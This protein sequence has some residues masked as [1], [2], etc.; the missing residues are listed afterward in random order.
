MSYV[1]IYYDTYRRINKSWGMPVE[2]KRTLRRPHLFSN[3]RAKGH[4]P[5]LFYGKPGRKSKMEK[6][7]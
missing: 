7:P 2:L 1:K 5:S 6:Y 4:Q 3:T